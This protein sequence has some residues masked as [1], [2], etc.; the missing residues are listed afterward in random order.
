METNFTFRNLDPTDALKEKVSE[1]LGKLKKYIIKPGNVHV[2]FSMDGP[3][4]QVEITLNSDGTQYVGSE[5]TNDV[6]I[7]INGAVSKLE[8]QLRRN[9]ELTKNHKMR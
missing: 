7:S 3:F 6:F 9:K 5:R 2:I 4:S 8:K 1:K